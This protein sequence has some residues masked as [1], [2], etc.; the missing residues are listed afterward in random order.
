MKKTKKVSIIIMVIAFCLIL[1]QDVYASILGDI[2]SK[3]GAFFS[4]GYNTGKTDPF[5]VSLQQSLLADG[6]IVDAIKTYLNKEKKDF[7]SFIV[8]IVNSNNKGKV[9]LSDFQLLLAE[10]KIEYDRDISKYD[11]IKENEVDI[12]L[13]KKVLG[14]ESNNPVEKQEEDINYP[15]S[16]EDEYNAETF[17]NND[18]INSIEKA[19]V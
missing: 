9:A 10:R 11:F 3:G 6:G 5:A 15:N 7:N 12:E 8:S 16:E 2:F 4:G 1:F 17:N 18:S 19:L 13:L 14:I